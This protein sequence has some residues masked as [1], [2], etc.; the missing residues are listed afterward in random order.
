VRLAI[1][2]IAAILAAHPAI[3]QQSSRV[4]L[5]DFG[6]G[7]LDIEVQSYIQVRDFVE[8][9]HIRSGLLLD[10]LDQLSNAGIRLAERE[11]AIR[12]QTDGG[13]DVI[14]EI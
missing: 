6:D 7:S 4:M 5:S 13:A 10:I 11:P 8:S 3:D 14:A 1:T 2:R 12:V 9:R